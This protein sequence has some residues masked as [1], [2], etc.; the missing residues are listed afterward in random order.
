M[1]LKAAL[2]LVIRDTREQN[3]ETETDDEAIE[4]A[5]TLDVDDLDVVEED[6]VRE[7]YEVFLAAT[8]EQIAAAK[9]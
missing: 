1:D 6:E 2:P 3:P 4:L 5:R 7:A 8:P 9:A